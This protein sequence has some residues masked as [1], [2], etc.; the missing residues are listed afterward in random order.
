MQQDFCWLCCCSVACFACAAAAEPDAVSGIASPWFVCGKCAARVEVQAT[1]LPCKP[2]EHKRCRIGYSNGRMARS[3]DA[4]CVCVQLAWQDHIVHV[5]LEST[6][7]HACMQ[8]EQET[9]LSRPM[10]VGLNCFN[11]LQFNC[12]E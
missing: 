6:C 9:I 8:P 12:N 3:I 10:V 2:T 4:V 5:N 1:L 11:D 7:V